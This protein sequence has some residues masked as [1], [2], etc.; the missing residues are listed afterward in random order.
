MSDEAEGDNMSMFIEGG[1]VVAEP[2]PPERGVL[3]CDGNDMSRGGVMTDDDVDL[4][5]N[6]S[7]P[8]TFSLCGV[9]L[10]CTDGE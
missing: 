1:G 6:R 7:E 10:E 4:C 9:R 8:L 2:L 5:R 3:C